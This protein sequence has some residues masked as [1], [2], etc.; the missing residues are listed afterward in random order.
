MN[1]S[2][3]AEFRE[4]SYVAIGYLILGIQRTMVLKNDLQ[5]VAS[6]T[7]HVLSKIS[8]RLLK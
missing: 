8:G 5:K 6:E 7:L 4:L 2:N 3:Q 1:E